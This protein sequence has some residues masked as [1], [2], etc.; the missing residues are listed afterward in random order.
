MARPSAKS[1]LPPQQ[2]G[3]IPLWC[4]HSAGGAPFIHDPQVSI[5]YPPNLL[6]MPIPD[7]LVGA[8]FSRLIVLQIIA[9]G[10]LA[11]AYAREGGLGQAGAFLTGAGFM[12]SGKWLPPPLPSGPTVLI[13]LGWVPPI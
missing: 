11:Y 2:T 3:E 9:A 12:L 7:R 1:V 4:P 5:F 10:L 6:L 13:G 8:A